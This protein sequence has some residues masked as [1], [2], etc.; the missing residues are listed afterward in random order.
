MPVSTVQGV[1]KWYRMWGNVR[2]APR[3]GRPTKYT[4]EVQQRVEAAVEANPWASLREI[5]ETLQDLNISHMTVD[6]ITKDLGFKLRIP[7]KKPFLDGF[8]KIR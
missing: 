2:D 6:K 7:G 8:T 3:P 5:T 4:P 1:V